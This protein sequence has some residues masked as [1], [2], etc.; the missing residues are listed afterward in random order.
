VAG[1]LAYMWMILA[2]V[3]AARRAI[4]GRDP[5]RSL[6]A[7]AASGGCIGFFAVNALFD[8]LPYPQAP[9]LFFVVGALTTVAS[10]G[11]EG[12]VPRTGGVPR[13][14]HRTGV[15]APA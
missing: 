8:T 10:G 5:T 6:L 9:Y 1:L 13:V 14:V 11:P 12:T 3:V 4:R 15:A 7:L 2:P